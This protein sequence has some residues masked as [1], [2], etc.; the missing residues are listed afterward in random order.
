[1]QRKILQKPD[2]PQEKSYYDMRCEFYEKFK[3]KIRPKILPFEKERLKKKR[4]ALFLFT[5][6]LCLGVLLIGINLVFAGFS[7]EIFVIGILFFLCAVFVKD[8]IAKAFERKIKTKIMANVCPCL[9]IYTGA[10]EIT[11]EIPFFWMLP[12]LFRGMIFQALTIFL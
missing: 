10:R 12:A 9:E 5:F 2:M 1:M 3:T 11:K 8:I 7:Q 6:F 4:F